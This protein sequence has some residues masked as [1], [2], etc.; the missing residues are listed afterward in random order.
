MVHRSCKAGIP[1]ALRWILRACAAGAL[2]LGG[3][4]V[5][6]VDKDGVR[7][8]IGF[9]SLVIPPPD[10]AA[11][12]AGHVIDVTTVGLSIS[13][14]P[15]SASV[16]LGYNRSVTAVLKDNALVLGNPLTI[17]GYTDGAKNSS[18]AQNPPY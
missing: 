8:V 6:Y 13:D 5:D 4:A 11:P 1:A 9:A 10:S 15:D 18:A 3:C 17:G 16:T 14:M 2:L 12:T 7:H